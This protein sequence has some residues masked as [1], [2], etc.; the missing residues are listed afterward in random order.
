MAGIVADRGSPQNHGAGKKI[1][2]RK[3]HALVDTNGRPLL[4]ELNRADIQDRDAAGPVL[5]ASR[6]IYP[7][8][9]R[10]FA[11]RTYASERVADHRRKR[12][13]NRRLGRL[14]RSATTLGG[15]TLLRLDQPKQAARKGRRSYHR[16]GPRLPLRARHHA[17]RPAYRQAS[18]TFGRTL[19]RGRQGQSKSAFRPVVA[20]P[21]QRPI[22]LRGDLVPKETVGVRRGC[23]GGPM[24][25]GREGQERVRNEKSLLQE[26]GVLH[27]CSLSKNNPDKRACVTWRGLVER[28]R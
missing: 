26:D 12:Q 27:I 19:R 5:E 24:G 18:V 23:T 28:R 13:K 21:W 14:G 7:F 10:L 4:I 22:I 17:H 3:R 6:A 16:L 9:A 25:G 1:E 20:D 15:R 8:I 2:G 11:D